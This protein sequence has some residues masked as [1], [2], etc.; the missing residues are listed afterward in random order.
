MPRLK[1]QS[2]SESIAAEALARKNL[3][4]EIKDAKADGGTSM[5]WRNS[6]ELL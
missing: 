3:E 5:C 1:K 6:F 4:Q 2:R